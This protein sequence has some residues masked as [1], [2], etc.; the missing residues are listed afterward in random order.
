MIGHYGSKYEYIWCLNNKGL[1]PEEYQKT[2]VRIAKYLSLNYIYCVMT[3]GFIIDNCGGLDVCF[4]ARKG[5]MIVNTWHGGGAYKTNTGDSNDYI[6][7]IKSSQVKLNIKAKTMRSIISS[8]EKFTSFTSKDSRCPE[9]RFL[10]IGMPRNDIFF[11][12]TDFAKTKVFN[13]YN[14]AK[15]KKMVLYA[16]TFRGDHREPENIEFS[17]G[18]EELLKALKIRFGAA[19][20][21]FYRSHFLLGAGKDDGKYHI[22][23]ASDYSDMQELLCAADVLITDYS[24]SIW[25]FSF[26]YKPCF[27]YVPDLEEYKFN[28]NFYTPIE[29]WPFPLAETNQELIENI[30]NFDDIEYIKNVKK[31]H[32]DLGSYETGHATERFCGL[33]FG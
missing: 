31:H 14:L 30:K 8:C 27:L 11:S 12:G 20:S 2:E 3:A 6:K 22:I 17:I 29:E 18:I 9:N 16:P 24:S 26:T 33:L 28:R 21:F 32:E 10:P 4:S 25:D 23:S 13:Y 15:N 7:R 5:Q 19:F 1:L